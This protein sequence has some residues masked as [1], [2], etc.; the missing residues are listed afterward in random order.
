MSM[1]SQRGR[2]KKCKEKKQTDKQKQT[3]NQKGM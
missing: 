3:N 2:G 1:I